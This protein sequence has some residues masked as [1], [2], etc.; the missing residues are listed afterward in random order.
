MVRYSVPVD[1]EKDI[2][3]KGSLQSPLNSI[4]QLA[5]KISCFMMMAEQ[6]MR[7]VSN[8]II[9]YDEESSCLQTYAPKMYIKDIAH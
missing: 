2:L 8:I 5:T 6:M 3:K 7:P 9:L 1:I 4:I